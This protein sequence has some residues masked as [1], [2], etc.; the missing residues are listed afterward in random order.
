MSMSCF[1]KYENTEIW[2]GKPIKHFQVQSK[3]LL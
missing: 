1:F 2:A 3:N